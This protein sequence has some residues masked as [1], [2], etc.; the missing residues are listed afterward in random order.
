MEEW[1]WNSSEQH[2]QEVDNTHER[3]APKPRF[4]RQISRASTQVPEDCLG[5]HQPELATYT[6]GTFSNAPAL[7][8]D[9]L[10]LDCDTGSAILFS[11][12]RNTASSF[13][14]KKEAKERAQ[15]LSAQR[16][17]QRMRQLADQIDNEEVCTIDPDGV[18]RGVGCI[19][20]VVSMDRPS[21][22][23]RQKLF[24]RKQKRRRLRDAHAGLVDDQR[25]CS[26]PLGKVTVYLQLPSSST[27][28]GRIMRYQH[29]KNA[30][31]RT[32]CGFHSDET[33]IMDMNGVFH[34]VFEG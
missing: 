5:Q 29:K 11:H 31:A 12:S 27:P 20:T 34:L 15:A 9:G 14:W 13:M 8:I 10:A 25:L 24:Y 3:D 19:E 26:D 17:L 33:I 16:F 4:D 6:C 22:A 30:R 7:T 32:A 28:H 21:F 18:V 2:E 23:S 1:H